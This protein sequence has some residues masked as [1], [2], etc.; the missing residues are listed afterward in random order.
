MNDIELTIQN[1]KLSLALKDV[2][3][4]LLA[5]T[6]GYTDIQN[7]ELTQD[8]KDLLQTNPPVFG[9][10]TP[11]NRYAINAANCNPELE[12]VLHSI[13][14]LGGLTPESFSDLFF[15]AGIR[16]LNT[17][18]LYGKYLIEDKSLQGS[19]FTIPNSVSGVLDADAVGNIIASDTDFNLPIHDADGVHLATRVAG[20]GLNH[21]TTDVAAP[22]ADFISV[23]NSLAWNVNV[24]STLE[25]TREASTGGGGFYTVL[26]EDLSVS[27]FVVNALSRSPQTRGGSNG[28][29]NLIAVIGSGGGYST[30]GTI[31]IDLLMGVARDGFD[32]IAA[33]DAGTYHDVGFLAFPT[34]QSTGATDPWFN[35]TDGRFAFVDTVVSPNSVI[36][37]RRL[38]DGASFQFTESGFGSLDF[39]FPV[40]LTKPIT[41]RYITPLIFVLSATDT[42]GEIRTKAKI[43]DGAGG[44]SDDNWASFFPLGL[45]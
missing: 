13:L 6:G 34:G 28:E 7:A 41:F 12:R 37:G 2:L 36:V 24:G 14:D 11:E 26:T 39:D 29:F 3:F 25:I 27:S 33:L 10:D 5:D 19:A 15:M 17:S 43:G 31:E 35:S 8:E 42:M 22:P 32:Y 30:I 45:T 1:S 20:D 40:D 18:Y 4:V 9:E 44:F 38:F 16:Q 23:A 21:A